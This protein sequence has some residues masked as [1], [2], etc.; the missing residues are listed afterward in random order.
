M[1]ELDLIK[2]ETTE[3][4]DE[5]LNQHEN[6]VVP[7]D[8]LLEV[9]EEPSLLEAKEEQIQ[10]QEQVQKQEHVAATGGGGERWPGWPGE[11]VFRILVPSQKVG[12][13]IG[14]KGEY[15]KK[16]V[17]ESKARIK[18]LDGPPGTPERAVMVSAKEE[19]E[20]SLPPAMDGLLRVHRRIVDGL[21]SDSSHP[22]PAVTGKV[23]TKL[24]VPAS[25]AGSLIGKQGTTVKSIQ[26]ASSC[27]V[28][29]LGTEDLPMFA[30]QDDRIVEVVGEPVGVHKAVELIASHLRKF[31]VDRGIIPVFE[32]QMQMPNPPVEHMPPPQSWGPPP[33]AFPPSAAG[34]P[35]YGNSPHF[36]PPPRQH[37]SYYPPADMPPPPLEKQPHQGISAYGREAPMSM[38]SSSNN[39]AAPSLVTQVSFVTINTLI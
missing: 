4:H 38:H 20:S 28:R 32:M 27:I 1:E 5:I 29:V 8:L 3:E 36:M 10:E 11:S 23:S 35:G 2:Q 34:G 39:P 24:L 19:P 9:K 14:R 6:E 30:L 25:Q 22:P 17:E 16:I 31:L 37:D 15:I 18:V 7:E 21:E 26:E 13:L 33:Q 12:G